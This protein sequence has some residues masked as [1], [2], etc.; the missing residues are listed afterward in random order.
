M[1]ETL[2]LSLHVVVRN[3]TVY[4]KDFI[5]NISPTLADPAFILL[6]L[7]FGL[8]PFV[9]EIEGMS[10]SRFLVPGMIATTALF[11]AFFECSY[12]FYVRLTFENV[13]K[14]MLTTPIGAREVLIG[15][16]IWV[17]LKGA[18][19]AFGVGLVLTLFGLVPNLY[20]LLLFPLIGGTLA[21]PCGA[22]GLVAAGYVRN[23]NQFQTVY[24]F[25]IAPLYFLSGTFFPVSATHPL[26]VALIQVSPFFHG[27]RLMQMAAWGRGSLGEVAYHLAVLLA[28]SLALGWWAWR[29]ITRKLV[30]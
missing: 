24:S 9:G 14:A 16:F 25:L 19:M 17:F 27:V 20:S 5:A 8:G 10:Y 2:G 6:A 7:G 3:W 1:I 29:G 26:F 22:M 12:G 4:K 23:I 18:V 15:E 11:T 21:V 28:F 30:S 13:F